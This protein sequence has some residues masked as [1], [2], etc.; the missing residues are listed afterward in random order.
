MAMMLRTLGRSRSAT[1][2]GSW[3]PSRLCLGDT[4]WVQVREASPMHLRRLISG[5]LLVS[6]V[7][8]GACGAPANAPSAGDE[9]AAAPT[10]PRTVKRITA[11]IRSAP[12]GL[13]QQR[14]LISVG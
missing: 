12:A 1:G 2:G 11:A 4:G 7:L 6:I 8:L 14:T 9:R 5:L 13:F 10:Q 3:H